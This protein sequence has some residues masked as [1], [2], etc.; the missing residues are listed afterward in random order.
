MELLIIN[1]LDWHIFIISFFRFLR[2][3]SLELQD[4]ITLSNFEKAQGIHV[5][6]LIT[7]NYFYTADAN[8]FGRFL[9]T[10][11]RNE[12]QVVPNL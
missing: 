3:R 12:S 1:I 10:F 7:S 9:S 2:S 4:E 11:F 6:G 8:A 5:L